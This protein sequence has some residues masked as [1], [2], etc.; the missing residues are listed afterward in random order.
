MS[1]FLIEPGRVRSWNSAEEN[2]FDTNER[3]LYL[4]DFFQVSVVVPK[5][6]RRYDDPDVVY[7]VIED[8]SVGAVRSAAAFVQG[9]YKMTGAVGNR[10]ADMWTMIGGSALV[11]SGFNIDPN[12]F[13]SH[14]LTPYLSGSNLYLRSHFLCPL[15][16]GG[17][18]TE[19]S[20]PYTVTL[21]LAVGGFN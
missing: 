12:Y 13:S 20:G 3:M 17:N 10:P 21:R 18:S 16:P 4:S 9:A 7:E 14:S 11:Y 19:V 2:T 8:I 1:E 6:T 5:Y 15:S